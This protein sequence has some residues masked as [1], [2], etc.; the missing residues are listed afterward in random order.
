M[1]NRKNK[2]AEWD[3]LTQT[4]P[5]KNAESKYDFAQSDVKGTQVESK[6]V[7]QSSGKSQAGMDIPPTCDDTSGENRFT[8]VAASKK[9]SSSRTRNNS[10]SN[11]GTESGAPTRAAT[12]TNEEE[13]D[14]EELDHVEYSPR[15][16][17]SSRFSYG[18]IDRG[19][20]GDGPY[21]SNAEKFSYT[22]LS[23]GMDNEEL[24]FNMMFF[25]EQGTGAGVDMT[26]FGLMI[27]N[28][29]QE[30]VALHSENNTPYKL[31]PAGEGTIAALQVETFCGGAAATATSED[32]EERE[33]RICWD[34]LEIGCDIIR[35]PKCGHFFHSECLVRWIK[36]VSIYFYVC[37]L[38]YLS[39]VRYVF[40]KIFISL[41]FV[42]SIR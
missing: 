32:E 39:Y 10:N 15:S 1:S 25:G 30:T 16:E 23:L 36:L 6:L 22:A 2:S 8:R 34:E 24:L 18:A 9:G 38:M 7:K 31:R 13:D 29:Q 37:I 20:R 28:A 4:A 21:D 33:C 5:P 41:F 26:N 35:L 42:V 19:D 17:C 40:G 14:A 27:D 12:I 3:K 11:S